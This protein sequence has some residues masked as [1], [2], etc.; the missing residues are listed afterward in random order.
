[1]QKVG[2]GQRTF[3]SKRVLPT[4]TTGDGMFRQE[5]DA[6]ASQILAVTDVC[7][8]NIDIAT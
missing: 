1:M 7:H 6:Q 8:A 2:E 3:A 4:A 5:F